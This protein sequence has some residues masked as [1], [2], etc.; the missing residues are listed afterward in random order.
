M[1]KL[2]CGSSSI[3]E[4]LEQDKDIEKAYGTKYKSKKLINGRR[5]YYYADER[6]E[7]VKWYEHNA[8]KQEIRDFIKESLKNPNYKENIKICDLPS[9]FSDKLKL[10]LG[11]RPIKL[12]MNS[13]GLRH[14]LNLERHNINPEDI[15]LLQRVIQNKH[16]IIRNIG[17]SKRRKIDLI[18]FVGYSR[19]TIK[20]V[21]AID[22]KNKE[23]QLFDCYRNGKIEKSVRFPCTSPETNAL[24]GSQPIISIGF[25][26]D[27][28]SIDIAKSFTGKSFNEIIKP[29]YNGQD[30]L[31]KSF[32]VEISDIT[33]NNKAKKIQQLEK[34]LY[35][36]YERK[37]FIIDRIIADDRAKYKDMQIYITDFQKS[38]IQDTVDKVSLTLA[39][40][41]KAV[42]G[43]PFRFKAMEDLTNQMIKELTE[44]TYKLY[45]LVIDYFGLPEANTIQ[46]AYPLTHKGKVLYNPETG[47]PFTKNDW[48]KFLNILDK[49]FN[50]NYSGIG[51]RIILKADALGRIMDRMLENQKD[52][53]KNLA[54]IKYKGKT[55]D[56]ITA[57]IKNMKSTFGESLTREQIARIQIAQTSCTQRI[58]KVTDN[59]RNDIQQL[60]IDGIK[61]K[62]PKVK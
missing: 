13:D 50:R 57:N 45:R 19:G 9:H 44:N 11:I 35:A 58:K 53:K 43:E 61:D 41:L 5:R 46:K 40:P 8:N 39:E 15:L 10:K 21:L 52:Y 48:Q 22:L 20:F 30:M 28:S 29:D 27:L 1:R 12:I 60:L 31:H 55:F 54:L 2:R 26:D 24:D 49:F 47:T 23:L 33:E 4:L 7:S 18:E 14:S 17:K 32:S 34:A 38:K 6:E 3:G 51:E 59:I 16:T 62:N 56:W 36:V 42:K 25:I 37:P